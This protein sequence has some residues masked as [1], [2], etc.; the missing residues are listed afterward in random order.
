VV[1][2]PVEDRVS[3]VP[4][5]AGSE[6]ARRLLAKTARPAALVAGNDQQAVGAMWVLARAG[7]SIPGQLSVTG[8]DDTRF[9]RLTA[10]DLT[11]AS[12]D[13]VAR[14]AS[15]PWQPPCGASSNLT[16]HRSVSRSRRG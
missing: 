8:Y 13:T 7:V 10:V 9:A 6:A 4:Q 12:Q 15:G 1:G 3:Q 16:C 11:T 2:H 14:W 5:E